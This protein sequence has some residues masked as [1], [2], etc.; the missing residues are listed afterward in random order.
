M[1][2][3]LDVTTVVVTKL[4]AITADGTP[5]VQK[6]VTTGFRHYLNTEIADGTSVARKDL[7]TRV[8]GDLPHT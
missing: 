2:M 8:W 4:A 6:D 3:Q 1:A 5:T 7:N